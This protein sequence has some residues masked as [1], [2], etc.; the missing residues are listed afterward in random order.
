MSEHCNI[1][2]ASGN[3]DFVRLQAGEDVCA[4]DSEDETTVITTVCSG[5]TCGTAVYAIRIVA[6]G[7][8]AIG[9]AVVPGAFAEGV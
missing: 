6:A 8:D 5:S 4:G 1:H 3:T 9:C 2:G 7:D